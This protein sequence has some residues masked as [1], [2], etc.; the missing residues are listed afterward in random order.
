MN[1]LFY[2]EELDKKLSGKVKEKV[3]SSHD[4]G[5][6]KDAFPFISSRLTKVFNENINEIL[7]E[8]VRYTN[9]FEEPKFTNESDY[10]YSEHAL[11]NNVVNQRNFENDENH[12]F[13]SGFLEDYLF[14]STRELKP[15][16]LYLFN[17]ITL[18]EKKKGEK[19][20]KEKY[21]RFIYDLLFYKNDEI[22][23]LFSTKTATNLLTELI[24]DSLPEIETKKLPMNQVENQYSNTIPQLKNLFID[25]FLYLSSHKEYFINHFFQLIHYYIFQYVLQFLKKAQRFG[26][27][28]REGLE[29][30]TFTFD[31]ESG[32]GAYR[33][34]VQ[35][36]QL[37]KNNAQNL[38]VHIHCM[39]HLSQRKE[40]KAELRSYK[41]LLD[42][43]DRLEDKDREKQ[44]LVHWIERY[45]E[46]IQ[47][48]EV[49]VDHASSFPELFK[50]LFTQLQKGMSEEVSIKY[51]R[52]IENLGKGRFLKA[53]G[54][55]GFTLSLKQDD[56]LM[57]SAVTVKEKKMTLKEF[58]KQLEKRG[59]TFDQ[60]SKKEAVKLLEQQNF[61]EKKSDSGDAK[62]VKPIL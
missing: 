61:I 5:N 27:Q 28:E 36:Y 33:E 14:K 43:L 21:S 20:E 6:I 10:T 7:G 38:F 50:K 48:T 41:D 4:T 2:F 3:L 1:D 60:Y 56:F 46:L 53:R 9:N 18:Q 23:S 62:Y 52:N 58:F 51:G 15:L 55:H 30:F 16:H 45:S 31:W 26:E 11:V 37:I 29:K 22:P 34:A 32:V 39:S 44:K 57:L 17:F 19:R 49:K 40:D 8:L 24:I 35:D 12:D 13:L 59:L 47:D 42:E 25:D 54:K